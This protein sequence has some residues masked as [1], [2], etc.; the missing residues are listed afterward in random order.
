MCP[1]HLDT[2]AQQLIYFRPEWTCGRYNAQADTAIMYN[3]IEGQ[4][5]FFESYSARV[6]GEIVSVPRNGSFNIEDVAVKTGIAV[7]SLSDFATTLLGVGLI[8]ERVWSKDEIRVARQRLAENRPKEKYGY[9][10]RGQVDFTT[11]E[12]DYSNS[13]NN[14]TCIASVMLELTYNCSERCVH[15]YNAGATRNDA[16]ISGRNRDELNLADYK[17]LID[18]LYEMGTY[19]VCLTGGD[20]FSKPVAWEIIDYLYA[21]GIAF[22]VF[23]NGQSI[24][25][26]AD[27][28]ADYYPRFVGLSVYSGIPEVHDR[29]TH[30]KGSF[31]KTIAV[32]ERLAQV[33]VPMSLKCVVFRTNIKSY[34]TVKP[35]AEK[36]GAEMQIEINLCNGVDGDMSIVNH[37]RLPK[38]VLEVLMRDPDVPMYIGGEQKVLGVGKKFLSAAP[39]RAGFGSYN[40]TPD[41]MVTPCCSFQLPLGSVKTQSLKEIITGEPLAKW[42]SAK[43]GDIEGCGKEPKCDYCYLCCGNNYSEFGT[44]FKPSSTNCFMAEVRYDLAQKIKSGNDPLGGLSVAERLQQM[45]VD[46]FVNFGKEIIHNN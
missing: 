21:K 26:K 32:A 40:I 19:K 29:I 20:P 39:C 3:L 12:E 38:D 17:R 45:Q 27:R 22:D 33:A 8:T 46:E 6:I 1:K 14:K 41:G 28:L 37:L 43:V 5:Y 4:S 23:T 42:C 15:C 2:M 9:S 16:E 36:Y 44:P 31:E 11:A 13:L 24:V 25:D 7:E 18:E 10:S 35:L 34:H 30:R